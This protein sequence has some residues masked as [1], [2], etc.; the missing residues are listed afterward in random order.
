MSGNFVGNPL[1]Q[2]LDADLNSE[3]NRA[4]IRF[5]LHRTATALR[6][7]FPARATACYSGLVLG[8]ALTFIPI[9]K[10]VPTRLTLMLTLASAGLVA[11]CAHELDELQDDIDEAKQQKEHDRQLRL[12]ADTEAKNKVAETNLLRHGYELDKSLPPELQQL[13]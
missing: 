4:I 5:L 8:F 2:L 12:Y 9:G 1:M 10:T 11:V 6:Y 13:V 7:V 3:R